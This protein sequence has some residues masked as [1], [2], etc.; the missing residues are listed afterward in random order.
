MILISLIHFN[1]TSNRF[2]ESES[3]IKMNSQ[4]S[5]HLNPPQSV[6]FYWEIKWKMVLDFRKLNEKTIG[7]SYPLPNI[8]DILDSVGSA[9]YFS[10]FD[11]VSGFH[12]I[13]MD[14]KD[15]HKTA[16]S[17]PH[18]HY[19]FDSMPFG[20]KTAP[21]TF[22]RLMDSTLIGLIGTELLVYLDDIVINANTLKEHKINFNDLAERLS[23]ATLHLQPDKN[24]FVRPNI[25]YLGHRINENGLRPDP[26]TI[27]PVKNF[28][29]PNTQQHFKQFVGLAEH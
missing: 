24:E 14:P 8:N 5:I 21:A 2:N 15:S 7:D 29:V 12:R 20:L 6:F 22:K 19:E 10:V 11:L 18:S 4:P 3:G 27:I 17:T 9:K 25:G 16:F 23:K 1:C 28:P 13:R 26:K